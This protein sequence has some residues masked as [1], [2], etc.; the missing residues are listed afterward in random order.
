VSLSVE[1]DPFDRIRAL[2]I[3]SGRIEIAPLTGGITNRNY[4]VTEAAGRAVV[5]IGG[6]IPAHGIMRF[7][8]HAASRAAADCGVSPAVRHAEPGLM[9][10]DFVAGTTLLPEGVRADL[11]R[12]VDLVRRAHREVTARLR[13]P[14]LSFNVFHVLRDY[15]HTLRAAGSSHA[16]ALPR[17]GDIATRLEAA[18]GPVDLVFGHNDLLCGNFIDDGARLWLID[19][20]YAGFNTPLFDLGGLSSNNGFTAADD[21]AMLERYFGSAP[22]PE[23]RRSYAAM[24]CASLLRETLWSMVSELHSDLDF[25][26]AAYTATNLARFEESWAGLEDVHAP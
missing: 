5:R 22:T 26:Y 14:A 13:G 6:D 23:L 15:A 19:W 10:I 1:S 12:C 24:R 18:V 21:E 20:D 8:E 9:V 4:L 3:W 11:G 16:R 7:N 25:D 17:L 2:P